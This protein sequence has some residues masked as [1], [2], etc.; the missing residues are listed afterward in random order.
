MTTQNGL[1]QRSEAFVV[2][3]TGVGSPD[4]V[5]TLLLVK[6]DQNDFTV[7]RIN[8]DT[9]GT[10]AYAGLVIG[11]NPGA[12]QFVSI[13]S[14]SAN[15]SADPSLAGD[16]LIN[17]ADPTTALRIQT[18]A[19][20]SIILQYGSSSTV[21]QTF[22]AATTRLHN[23]Q[24]VKRT[25]P[26]AYPYAVLSTDYIVEVDTSAAR[27][28]QLPN[29]PSTGQQYV[30]KDVV[31]TASS[32]NITLTTVGGS[33]TIDGATSYIINTNYAAIKVYFNGT[34]YFII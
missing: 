14:F 32:F 7:A 20:K 3:P 28:I 29:A 17:S 1:N 25:V 30:I 34:S 8:N 6:K 21:G 13:S 11:S 19:S 23:G 16:A 9:N 5:N 24:I 15:Y 26:G 27:T 10:N 33:V 18:S 2:A 31:G 22:T 4:P 12:T